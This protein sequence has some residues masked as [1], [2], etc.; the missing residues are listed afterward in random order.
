MKAFFNLV[1]LFLL[2]STSFAQELKIVQK[3][4]VFDETRK[5]LSLEYLKNRHGLTQKEATIKPQM[6]VL[7][8]TASKSFMSTFHTF[9]RSTLDGRQNLAN[10]SNLNVSAHYLIDRDGTVYQLLPDTVFARHVIGL[11]YGAI[12][13]ENVGSADYPLTKAQLK[14][15]ELLVRHLAKKFSITH[16][17]GHYEHNLF[18]KDALWKET[19]PKYQTQKT[20]PGVGFMRDVR[21][22]LKDLN[23]KGAPSKIN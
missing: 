19:N 4:I 17:I 6:V 21:T 9:N 1:V 5:K 22:A 15:N 13:V 2:T 23:L 8:W 12:G 11:N 16:L 20:D 14:A 7:H 18:K 3:P 10:A